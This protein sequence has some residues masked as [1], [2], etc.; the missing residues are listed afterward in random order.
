MCL[1]NTAYC[2]SPL[3]IQKVYS[4]IKGSKI[5]VFPADTHFSKSAHYFLFGI[6]PITLC[7]TQVF[8]R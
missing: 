1:G 7:Q 6:S 8:H 2:I 5:P 3:E 4:H